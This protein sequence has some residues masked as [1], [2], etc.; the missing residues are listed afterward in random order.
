MPGRLNSK[1]AIVTGAAS[2][3]GAE[4]A[5]L[6]VAEGAR[7]AAF[8]INDTGL[9]ALSDL[10]DSVLPVVCDLTDG[11]AV[12]GGVARVS[13]T[14]GGVHVLYNNAGVSIRRPGAWDDSQDGPTADITEELFDRLIS[15]NLKS[16]FLTCKYAIPEMIA[17]GGGSIVNVAALAGVFIGATNNAYCASKGGV[18]GLTLGLAWAYGSKGIRANALCP[19]LV[20]TPLVDHVIQNE[21][22]LESY[23]RS[24]PL[25]RVAQPAEIAAM[26]LFLASDEASYLTGAVIPVDGGF[27]RQNFG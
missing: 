12:R 26:G 3:Q 2:G 7:V 27:T 21:R 13:E 18:V 5:R 8:D 6:F 1:V 11:A 25:G 14:F 15:I 23:L 9:A 17:S 24:N 19:G 16:Q 22:F 10:G 4:V 20:D